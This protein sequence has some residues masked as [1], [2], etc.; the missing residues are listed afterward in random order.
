MLGD[1]VKFAPVKFPN[2]KTDTENLKFPKN[3]PIGHREDCE[4]DVYQVS[5][6][7]E[8][9]KYVKSCT[10]FAVNSAEKKKKKERRQNRKFEK[11][12]SPEP[13]EILKRFKR[14]FEYLSVYEI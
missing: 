4:D 9:Y 7:S 10:K 13:N 6:Q 12:I 2:L 8:D 14:L 11:F 1:Q 5:M 3:S